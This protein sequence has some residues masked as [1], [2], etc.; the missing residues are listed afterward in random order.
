MDKEP[1]VITSLFAEYERTMPPK[2][3]RSTELA[4]SGRRPQAGNPATDDCTR[5]NSTLNQ[6]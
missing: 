1:D 3:D 2:S 5:Q 4:T 6:G